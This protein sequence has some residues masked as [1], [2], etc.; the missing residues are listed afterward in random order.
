[1][2]EL[3]GDKQKGHKHADLAIQYWT[4][5][6]EDAEAWRNWEVQIECIGNYKPLTDHPRFYDYMEYRR[7]PKVKLV[8]GF[9]VPDISFV[10]S[11]N[12]EPF[13]APYPAQPFMAFEYPS[14]AYDEVRI[15]FSALNSCYP[16]TEEGK[17]AAIKHALAMLGFGSMEEYK[18][19]VE[20][21]K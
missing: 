16:H 6:K 8:H 15:H 17:Q 11:S 12:D 1:M 7:K 21:A 9:E 14:G 10:P 2:I 19:A 5:A 18:K 13:Y 3:S 20:G 4:E